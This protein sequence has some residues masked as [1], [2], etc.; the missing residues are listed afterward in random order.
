MKF[1]HISDLHL[2]RHER[3][4]GNAMTMFQFIKQH[5]PD[6]K[7]IVTGNITDDGHEKQYN[8]AYEALKP[9][10]GN[11][12]ICPGNHD[13]G[14]AGNFYSRERGERFDEILSIPLQQGGTFTGDLTPVNAVDL[15]P[16]VS[17]FAVAA[18]GST[19]E[20]AAWPG[21]GGSPGDFGQTTSEQL[22][23]LLQGFS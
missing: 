7:L 23:A 21:P 19:R 9:F 22:L 4:N 1:L 14:A 2:H 17:P 15:R 12:F 6:H 11:V 8:R 3:D 16:R 13:F 10:T 18:F 20:F 5:Y